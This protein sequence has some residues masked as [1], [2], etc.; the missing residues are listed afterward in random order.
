MIKGVLLSNIRDLNEVPYMERF[1]DR[2]HV[3]DT[4]SIYGPLLRRWHIYRSETS[5]LPESMPLDAYGA[6]NWTVVE[7]HFA[8]TPY[9]AKADLGSAG[10]ALEEYF[11]PNYNERMGLPSG[12]DLKRTG[13]WPGSAD[14]R[15]NAMIH[16]PLRPTESFAGT[17]ITL[18]DGPFVRWVQLLR[19][20]D[21]VTEESFEK[22]YTEVHAPEVAQMPHLK[23]FVSYR[24]LQGF[25]GAFQ[26]LS[27]LWFPDFSI[28]QKDVVEAPPA[29][30]PPPWA[31]GAQYPFL[32]PFRE[33][34][35]TFI[36]ERPTK[37][38]LQNQRSYLYH[39]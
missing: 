1:V 14:L 5:L 39:C 28:W 30:T 9:A 34:V 10:A 23:R 16:V 8:E 25:P 26:R 29:M 19:V 35:S 32:R 38:L 15:L 36:L 37:D 12:K 6:Y 24:R 3:P 21:G 13:T 18:A 17:G 31:K 22:W 33:M 20:P 27:E 11:P 2:I 7:L 4:L